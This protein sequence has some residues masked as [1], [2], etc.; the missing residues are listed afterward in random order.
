[1]ND[2]LFVSRDG[3]T[4]LISPSPFGVHFYPVAPVSMGEPWRYIEVEVTPEAI[5]A[6][7]RDPDGSLHLI[8]PTDEIRNTVAE[9]RVESLQKF[10]TDRA[11]ELDERMFKDVPRRIDYEPRGALGL[12]VKQAAVDFRNVVYERLPE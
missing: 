1:M 8:G 7:W 4:D 9:I 5:R 6:R 10:T 12:F 11:K 2:C 3:V